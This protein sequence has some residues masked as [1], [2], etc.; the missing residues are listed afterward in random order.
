MFAAA[1]YF[2]WGVFPL[3]FHLLSRT[4]AFEVIA[5]RII[6]SLVFCLAAVVIGR[7]WRTFVACWRNP[8]LRWRFLAAGLLITAN[9]TIYVWGVNNGHT[10]DAA[11]G[12]FFNPLV[13]A[14]LG[15]LVLKETLSRLQWVAFGVGAL[16]VVILVIAYG[17]VPWVALGV[18]FSF[19]FYS[20]AKKG[21][22]ATPPDVGLTS[23]TLVALPLAL[24]WMGWLASQGQVT[25]FDGGPGYAALLLLLGPIT[26]IPLLLF[27]ASAPRINLTTL[28][29]VQYI[30]PVM[31][32]LVGWLIFREPMPLGRWLGFFV[33]WVAVALFVADALLRGGRSLRDARRTR[34]AS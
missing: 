7:R 29:M 4:G 12:Y 24:A 30:S 15:V 23:E 3:Y 27:A 2:L 11:L 14:L 8:A 20:L 33:V 19:A 34:L 13:T 5:H 22:G 26:A 10:L 1:C 25:T 6:W 9:W 16:A 17:Q 31:Q 32:F 21:F 28:G 18:S